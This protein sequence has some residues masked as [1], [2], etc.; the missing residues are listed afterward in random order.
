L[1]NDASGNTLQTTGSLPFAIAPV[2][3]LPVNPVQAGAS[4]QVTAGVTPNLAASQSATLTIGSFSASVGPVDASTGSLLFTFTPALAAG[5][6][7]ARLTVDGSP[8]VIGVNWNVHP[9]VF[10]GPMVTI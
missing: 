5:S 9:P 6:Y 10:T 8:S 2:L 1:F 4:T 7:L 3:T